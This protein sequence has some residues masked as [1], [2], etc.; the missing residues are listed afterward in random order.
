MSD[1]RKAGGTA[2]YPGA[3]GFTLIELVVVMGLLTIFAAFLIQLMSTS[4]SLF[5]QGERGQDMSD[6]ADAAARAIEQS[7]RDM[8][9]PSGVDLDGREPKTR[10]LAQ[11]V[12][13]VGNTAATSTVAVAPRVQLLRATVRIDDRTEE[14][15]LRP[16]LFQEATATAE[17]KAPAQIEARLRELIALAPRAGRATMLLVP[18]PAGDPEGAFFSVRRLLQLPGQRIPID[19]RHD[20]DLL[21]VAEVGSPE[22]PWGVVDQLSESIAEDVIHLEFAF[23]S[24]LTQGWDQRIGDGG[25]EFSWDS[26]RAGLFAESNDPREMFTLDVGPASLV[27]LTDDVF[28][29]WIRITL[30]VAS[31]VGSEAILAGE[32]RA[33]DR[34]V[35]V[36]DESLL[37]NPKDTPMVKVGREWLRVGTLDGRA[38]RGLVRGQRGTKAV[39]HAAGTR[40]RV[41]RTIELFVRVA[42]G[43]D[44]WNGD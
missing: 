17:G 8:I 1:S 23:W 27:D 4:V 43:K 22:L 3:A 44:C 41:G 7:V 39:D 40:V 5:Q 31:P 9:G 35:D 19:R 29:R 15:L 11:W 28:P 34:G 21:E 10:L 25:P 36:I 32:L 16:V 13:G 26:A 24:Q 6:R 12:A 42:H 2:P 30:V 37:P 14:R 38:L 33:S 20:V 18:R